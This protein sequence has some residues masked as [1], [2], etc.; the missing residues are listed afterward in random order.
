MAQRK[1]S[2]TYLRQAQ[3]I[4]KRHSVLRTG[5]AKG[6]LNVLR[7]GTAYLAQA[8][9]TRTGTAYRGQPHRIKE[10]HSVLRTL[11][12]AYP[13]PARGAENQQFHNPLPAGQNMAALQV[14]SIRMFC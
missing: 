4:E 3:R 9:R 12:T 1:A 14:S 7:T 11:G 6:Q 2:T 10:K 5:T 8:Q 13:G